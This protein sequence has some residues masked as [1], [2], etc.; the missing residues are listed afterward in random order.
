MTR[1]R[2]PGVPNETEVALLGII[3]RLQDR[4]EA[5]ERGPTRPAVITQ[6]FTARE[7]QFLRVQAPAAGLA[8]LLP[9]PQDANRNARVTFSMETAHPVTIRCVGG[10]VNP[11]AQV[12]STA[13]GT[14]E[15]ISDGA[16]G[17]SVGQGISSSGSP[18]DAEYLVGA[19]HG[20]LP[21]ARVGT[22]ST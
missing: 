1:S 4:I 21:N 17:W 16:N 12:V 7:G 19:A 2:I 22:D 6:N 13:L 9:Q 8:I 20:S 10:V 15:A 5:L 18:T 3:R 14:F 11:E